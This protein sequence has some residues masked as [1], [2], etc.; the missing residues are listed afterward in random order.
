MAGYECVGTWARNLFE[1]RR[2]QRR[3]RSLQHGRA[4]FCARVGSAQSRQGQRGACEARYVQKTRRS[5]R[6]SRRYCRSRRSRELLLVA[7]GVGDWLWPCCPFN[8]FH[9]GGRD[10]GSIQ[11]FPSSGC[12]DYI[13]SMGRDAGRDRRRRG[14]AEQRQRKQ[15]STG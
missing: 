1:R 15:D 12:C 9:V 2:N 14:E 5:V 3:C 10:R 4:K 6:S 7:A 8:R 13:G 11:W